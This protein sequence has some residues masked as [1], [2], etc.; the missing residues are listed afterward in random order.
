MSG[1]KELDSRSE[2]FKS[3]KAPGLKVLLFPNE[4]EPTPSGRRKVRTSYWAEFFGGLCT[5]AST[6]GFDFDELSEE[7]HKKIHGYGVEYISLDAKKKTKETPPDMCPICRKV[8]VGPEHI[9]N[10]EKKSSSA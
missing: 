1:A 8:N 7:M 9:R 4:W 3:L 5:I 10:C 2:T 6:P